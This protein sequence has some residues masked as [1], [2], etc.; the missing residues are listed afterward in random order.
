MEVEKDT[1]SEEEMRQKTELK[2][3]KFD[4]DIATKEMEQ[5]SSFRTGVGNNADG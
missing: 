1:Y 5:A 2:M 4:A 3:A